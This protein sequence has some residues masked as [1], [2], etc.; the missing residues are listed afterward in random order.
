M[1]VWFCCRMLFGPIK[2]VLKPVA[3]TG[4]LRKPA[5]AQTLGT[6]KDLDTMTPLLYLDFPEVWRKSDDGLLLLL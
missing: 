3:T 6:L 2:Y 1:A 4:V 5:A